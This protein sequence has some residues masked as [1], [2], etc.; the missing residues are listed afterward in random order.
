MTN[1]KDNI[2]GAVWVN[3]NHWC[4]FCISLKKWTY[5]SIFWTQ[6][7]IKIQLT[8]W[9]PC[10]GMFSIHFESRQEIET[11]RQWGVPANGWRKLRDLGT[12]ILQKLPF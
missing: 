8:R 6:E 10:S 2:V 9:S 1:G 5:T 3:K 12:R 4:A 7:T 11:R